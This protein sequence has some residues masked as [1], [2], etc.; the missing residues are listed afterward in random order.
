MRSAA[1]PIDDMHIDAD[2]RLRSYI[3]YN[4][5]RAYYEIQTELSQ[6]LKPLGLKVGSFAVLSAIVDSPGLKQSEL[7]QA[8]AIEQ[9]NLVQLVDEFEARG[10]VKRERASTDRRAYA[11]FATSTGKT[12]YQQA[13]TLC[14][15]LEAG[16]LEG[17]S[18]EDIARFQNM[19]QTIETHLKGRRH[20]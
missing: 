13:D 2:S 20:D 19:L 1:S 10:L 3:G 5:K 12:L 16:F 14:R 9:A 4:M 17:Y 7:A 8:L 6:A 11:L 15:Q 18:Q